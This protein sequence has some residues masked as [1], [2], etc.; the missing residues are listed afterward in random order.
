M[1]KTSGSPAARPKVSVTERNLLVAHGQSKKLADIRKRLQPDLAVEAK[2]LPN[3]PLF[4][5]LKPEV[6][7]ELNK[8]R[9][10][11]DDRINEIMSGFPEGKKNKLFSFRFGS[12]E[13]VKA[14]DIKAAFKLLGIDAGPVD[15]RLLAA[16][17]FHGNT[18]EGS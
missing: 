13:S 8:A 4:P 6:A 12:V 1:K 17:N 3:K 15:M 2:P 16:L 10:L 11:I 9:K 18:V 14:A 5:G 7:T